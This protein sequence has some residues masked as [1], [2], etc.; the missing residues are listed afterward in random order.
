[1]SHWKRKK[2]SKIRGFRS[3]MML[4]SATR[5]VPTFIRV[6]PGSIRDVSSMA[7]T[8]DMVGIE[9][10]VIVTDK[11]FFSADNLKA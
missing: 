2:V 6:L 11:E 10:C 5:T 1:M 3:I 7:N 8:I 9:K 4:F